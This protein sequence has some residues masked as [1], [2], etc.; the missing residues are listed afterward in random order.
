[1]NHKVII[2]L[3]HTT[4]LWMDGISYYLVIIHTVNVA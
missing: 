4:V 1:M 3:G 2:T